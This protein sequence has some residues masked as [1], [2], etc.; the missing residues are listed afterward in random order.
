MSHSGDY[1]KLHQEA[2]IALLIRL[3]VKLYEKVDPCR[4]FMNLSLDQITTHFILVFEVGEQKF[5]FQSLNLTQLMDDV[6]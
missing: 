6:V 3:I 4:K 1:F 5:T 2:Y